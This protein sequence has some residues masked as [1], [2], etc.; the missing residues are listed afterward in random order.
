MYEI[1][2]ITEREVI[3]SD[4][5]KK[6]VFESAHVGHPGIVLTQ[7][8]IAKSYYW[9][10]LSIELK[11]MVSPPTYSCYVTL[12]NVCTTF[13]VRRTVSYFVSFTMVKCAV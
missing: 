6:R 12:C 9:P 10:N 3:W 8:R 7:K 5:K 2:G 1:N 13:I 11:N 4:E